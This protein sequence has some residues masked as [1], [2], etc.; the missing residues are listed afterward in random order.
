[1][2]K[3]AHLNNFK[4]FAGSIIFEL[5]EMDLPL[6]KYYESIHGGIDSYSI[7]LDQFTYSN[8]TGGLGIFGSRRIISN[9]WSL[10]PNY[11]I[12]FIP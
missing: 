12:L 3:I 10:D 5:V 9:N 1:M 7:S 4:N 8:I 11:I 6:S 2:S